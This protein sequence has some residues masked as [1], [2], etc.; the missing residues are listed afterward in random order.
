M[1]I[2]P[3]EIERRTF[4]TVRKGFA[5]DEVR[6]F[7]AEIAAEH[8]ANAPRPGLVQ[9]A[10]EVAN[11]LESAHRTAAE[12]EANARARAAAI[13][14][15]ET[16]RLAEE[17]N[18]VAQMRATVDVEVTNARAEAKRIRGEAERFATAER[19][20][21][22]KLRIEA[23]SYSNAESSRIRQLWSE[24]ETETVTKRGVLDDEVK[25]LR[26]EAEEAARLMRAQ[27]EERAEAL[28]READETAQRRRER[29]EREAAEKVNAAEEQA[30]KLVA[31]AEAQASR[32]LDAAT[33]RSEEVQRDAE[34]KAR[35][36]SQS[37]LSQSQERLDM[38]LATERR[39][40]ERL[41]TALAEL[42]AAVD[43]V[44]GAEAPADT[45]D[46]GAEPAR[47]TEAG[48]PVRRR[49]RDLATDEIDLTVDPDDQ[50]VLARGVAE[51]VGEALRP[52]QGGGS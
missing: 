30:A 46:A 37:V 29:A 16:A 28:R 22:E 32:L 33:L 31:D 8:R 14:E 19:T 35:A 40:H 41:R 47:L 23:E 15:E 34:E 6:A 44:S 3:E 17:R 18:E 49:L 24:L 50:E 42:Q 27:A 5:P 9:V 38:I 39:A 26:G 4:R 7:L 1:S 48:L 11:V 20:T 2:S 10:D 13:I 12:I 51:A 45:R 25:S 52:F 43:M 21:A 36:H